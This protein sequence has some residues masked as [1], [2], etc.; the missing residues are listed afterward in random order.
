MGALVGQG[1]PEAL[2]RRPLTGREVAEALPREPLAGRG[3]PEA[4][5]RSTASGALDEAFP[6]HCL[7]GPWQG[8]GVPEALPQGPLAGRGVPEGLRLL[9]QEMFANLGF[10][11]FAQLILAPPGSSWLFLGLSTL[12]RTLSKTYGKP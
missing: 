6:R 7:E 11:Y 1:V 8:K 3:V 12:R 10:H 2:P 5:P 9:F 4:L